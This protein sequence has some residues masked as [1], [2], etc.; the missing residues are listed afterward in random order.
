VRTT[1]TSLAGT[2]ISASGTAMSGYDTLHPQGARTLH[3]PTGTGVVAIA[4]Y[5]GFQAEL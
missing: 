3:T 5:A 2:V 4:V 1:P